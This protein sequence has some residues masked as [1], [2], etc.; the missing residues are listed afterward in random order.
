MTYPI[1]IY[2]MNYTLMKY[3][4]VGGFGFL[5]DFSTTWFFKEIAIINPFIANS[6]GF[7]MA[8]IWNFTLNKYWTFDQ[9]KNST[10]AQFLKFLIIS[11]T[12]LILNNVFLYLI[13]TNNQI[14]FYISKLIVIAIVFFWNYTLN[15]YYTFKK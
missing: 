2:Q 4:T 1:Y 11:I 3:A 12:G 13:I 8:V 7:S 5:I 6:F 9:I 14:N 10:K 15:V